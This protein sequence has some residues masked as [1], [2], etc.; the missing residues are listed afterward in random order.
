MFT[1]L[2]QKLGRLKSLT[3]YGSGYRLDVE[4]EDPWDDLEVGESIAVN[5]ACLTLVED[6]GNI[7]S[8]DV[9]PETVRKTTMGSL[10]KGSLLNLE[11]ALRLSDR[12]GGH[13]VLGHVDG[14][15]SITFIRNLSGFY[16][17]GVRVPGHLLR[18]VAVKGSI[19]VDGISLTVAEKS[20]EVI[21]IAVI[22]H[23]FENTNLRERRVGDAVNIEVDVIARYIEALMG[24]GEDRLKKLLEEW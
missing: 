23:T 5:G 8:F 9:S 3:P 2:V 20:G 7:L 18:Y 11:R 24:A 19:A 4:V 13:L 10:K 14:V 12:L 21:T 16:S 15:G 6:K 1:G 17:L 22:P